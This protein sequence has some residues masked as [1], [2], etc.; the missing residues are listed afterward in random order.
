MIE[1][2]RIEKINPL[3]YGGKVGVRVKLGKVSPID[4]MAHREERREQAERQALDALRNK[5]DVLDKKM[6]K[7]LDQPQQ[8]QS[9]TPATTVTVAKTTLAA[10]FK[11]IVTD[12]VNDIP[13]L[14]T[15]EVHD[16][17]GKLAGVAVSDANTGVFEI[18]GVPL[19]NTYSVKA[20][21]FGYNYSVQESVSIDKNEESAVRTFNIK[22]NRLEKD[23]SFLLRNIF[24]ETG[25][26]T[27]EP[28]SMRE[29][30]HLYQL[31]ID[32]P[33]LKIEVSGHTDNV[34]GAE[35]NRELSKGRAAAVVQVLIS[36]GIAADRL[37]SAGY[38]FDR[39]KDTNATP[40][41]RAQ[42]RRVEFKVLEN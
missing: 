7:L 28:E 17:A 35:F 13:L 38:G 26:T 16:E 8:T 19:G 27:L 30:N 33:K 1:S 3:A 24:F 39:P 23:G 37:E 4:R 25:K 2:N 14:A 21:K 34:G 11:G 6:D 5:V 20:T 29:I 32:N 12:S 41:G 31:M 18:A 9:T 36:K 42:N 15:V 10:T 40:E 22:L